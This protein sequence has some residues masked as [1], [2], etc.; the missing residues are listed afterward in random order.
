MPVAGKSRS[1]RR[2]ACVSRSQ[3]SPPRPTT[4]VAPSSGSSSRCRRT[5]CP[6]ST[7]CAR[8]AANEPRSSGRAGVNRDQ[9]LEHHPGPDEQVAGDHREP[10]A[11]EVGEDAGRHLRE[12]AGHLQHRADE[13]ELERAEPDSLDLVDE[14]ECER[15]G[16][17]ERAGRA[18]EQVGRVGT[19]ACGLLRSHGGRRTSSGAGG[20]VRAGERPNEERARTPDGSPR[21]R[22]AGRCARLSHLLL[23]RRDGD[24]SEARPPPPEAHRLFR[25]PRPGAVAYLTHPASA[26]RHEDQ[27]EGGSPPTT[28][29]RGP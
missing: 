23:G 26:R 8:I 11:V 27:R 18:Q 17:G 20:G 3:P 13:H 29:C 28:E 2:C 21:H 6:P 22:R 19:H 12:E 14:V 24:R 16:A 15:A 25:R 9:A 5:A 1:A 10:P 7:S 4:K